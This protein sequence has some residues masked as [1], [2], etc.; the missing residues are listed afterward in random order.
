[1]LV[2][3][4]GKQQPR[5]K[6]SQQQIFDVMKYQNKWGKK[7]ERSLITTE[8]DTKADVGKIVHKSQMCVRHV[9]NGKTVALKHN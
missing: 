8:N 2:L 1:M 6:K 3:E 9:N 7:E 5:L 4:K